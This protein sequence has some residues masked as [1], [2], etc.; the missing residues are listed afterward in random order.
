MSAYFTEENS[1]EVVNARM[2]SNTEP[3]FQE[4]MAALVKHLHAFA[5]EIQ[6]RPEE[7]EAAIDFLTRTGQICSEERQ[8]FILLSDCLGLSM[9]VDAIH[10]RRPTGATE[11]TVFGPFL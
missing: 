7:W 8:E 4:V 11:N 3:R 6:L 2:G 10:H 9:L 1:A 5:K